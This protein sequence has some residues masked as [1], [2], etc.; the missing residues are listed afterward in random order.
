MQSATEI[1][2]GPGQAFLRFVL[3]ASLGKPPSERTVRESP[4]SLLVV[5][6]LCVARRRKGPRGQSAFRHL[7][8]TPCS[9]MHVFN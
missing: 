3:H 5:L 6:S 4:C 1:D 7:Q 9:V 2:L 8:T